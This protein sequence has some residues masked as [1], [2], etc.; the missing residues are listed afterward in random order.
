MIDFPVPIL[1]YHSISDR[2]S[3]KFRLWS[4]TPEQ[5][6]AQ[7]NYLAAEH[8]APMTVSDFIL[9]ISGN[10]L[11]LPSR[12]IVISFDDGFQDFY[13]QAAP[14]LQRFGFPATLYV[15]T[16]Y[17]G[18]SSRWLAAAGE[19]DRPILTWDQVIDLSNLGIEIGAHTHTHPQ[20]DT[21][22]L[23][24]AEKEIRD[25][26]ALLEDHLGNPIKSFA[27]P[28]GYHNTKVKTLVRNSAF[29]SACAV[30][31]AMSGP[32]DDPFALA[33]IMVTHDLTLGA[34]A[35]L[36]NGETLHPVAD[37]ERIQTSV[38][39]MVRRAML[40]LRHPEMTHSTHRQG[41]SSL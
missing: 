10:D 22:P 35:R 18:E 24:Q 13:T 16:G 1:L 21:L 33:R 15:V 19:G 12:P 39:R 29:Q 38:W 27:Y 4:V 32:N 17:I 7:L 28:Y 3:P 2:V 34:F 31:H 9:E 41:G 36:L 8:Y 26:K 11:Q 14:V 6:E 37:T 20:L 40:Q 23:I 25:S 30:K 5:F